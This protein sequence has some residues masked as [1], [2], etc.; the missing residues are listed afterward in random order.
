MD[1]LA[2]ALVRGAEQVVL[3][4]DQDALPA[5]RLELPEEEPGELVDVGA[6][7]GGAVGTGG[8]AGVAVQVDLELLGGDE[9]GLVADRREAVVGRAR[10][11]P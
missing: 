10:E 4:E 6:L 5:G 2:P 7:T 8:N 11:P 1:E 3:R 9:A